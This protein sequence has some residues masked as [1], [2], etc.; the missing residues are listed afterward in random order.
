MKK[1]NYTYMA[2]TQLSLFVNV[3]ASSEWEAREKADRI[4]AKTPLKDWGC[5]FSTELQLVSSEED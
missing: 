3:A 4:V 2:T 1:K 5:D